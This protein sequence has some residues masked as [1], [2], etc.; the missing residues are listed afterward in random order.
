M[1]RKIRCGLCN[2]DVTA[3]N[4]NKHVERHLKNPDSFQKRKYALNHEGLQCQFC[5]KECKN[6]NSLC[7][8][9]R[10]CRDNPDRQLTK[11]EKYGPIEGFNH[12]GRPAWNKGLTKETDER[13]RKISD[14]YRKHYKEGLITPSTGRGKTEETEIG[15]REKLS[16]K[17]KQTEFWKYK[18]K[19]IVEYNGYKFD[20]SYEVEVAKSLD[21]NNIRWEKPKSFIYHFN[22]AEHTYT[23]DFYLPDFDVYLDPKNDFLIENINPGTGY[24]D[25]DKIKQVELENNI[26]IIILDKYNLTW[27]RI[28]S[29]L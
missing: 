1:V 8:H 29:I 12:K 2:V 16:K 15:R 11:Y 20:S 25:V 3:N 28:K 19:H 26:K 13:V 5:G 7:N 6:R 24:R 4:Y 9:E 23:A 27:D 18:R 10:L 21:E 22:D 14:T 17:A